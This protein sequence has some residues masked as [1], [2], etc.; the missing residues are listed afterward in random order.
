VVV[1]DPA[2]ADPAR[3]AGEARSLWSAGE[4]GEGETGDLLVRGDSAMALYW[5]KD[6]A[7]RRTLQ[8]EW[9]RTGDKYRRDADGG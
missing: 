5:N 4:L 9:V 2:L 1:H 3:L 6:D 7:S 8:G